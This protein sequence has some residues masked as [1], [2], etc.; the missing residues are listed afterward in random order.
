[1]INHA[2]IGI[3]RNPRIQGTTS[4]YFDGFTIGTDRASTEDTAFG[5]GDGA[6]GGGDA[7]STLPSTLHRRAPKVVLRPR[8]TSRSTLRAA[9]WPHVIPVYG[10]VKGG[11]RLGGRTVTIEI[12]RNG[13]WQWLTRGWLRSNGR[14]YLAPA[15]DVGAGRKVV[16]RAHVSRVGYSRAIS[17]R[18]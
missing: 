8:R 14:Y 9:G 11:K 7:P 17:A 1:M 13:R 4:I 2:R 5:A 10:W 6:Q 16:L 12:R 15:V 3:Y 18:V